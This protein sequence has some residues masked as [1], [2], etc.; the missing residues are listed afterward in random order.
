MA[1]DP[2][3]GRKWMRVKAEAY[4]RDSQAI[5][6]MPDGSREVGA[7]CWICGDPIDYGAKPQTPFAWEPDHFKPVELYPE[8]AYDLANIRPAH[9]KCNRRRGI[10]TP[11]RTAKGGLGTPSRDWKTP[12]PP[13]G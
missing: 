7:R 5:V 3:R 10:G 8:L 11:K 12:Q 6:T 1:V 13:Q 9:S 4:R 2:R